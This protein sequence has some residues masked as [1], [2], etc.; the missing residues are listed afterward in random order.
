MPKNASNSTI[1]R[2]KETLGQ[3]DVNLLFRPSLSSSGFSSAQRAQVNFL[4]MRTVKNK[5]SELKNNRRH[6]QNHERNAKMQ[7]DICDKQSADTAGSCQ[8][9][10]LVARQ[11]WP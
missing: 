10:I 11:D 4:Q 3:I 5:A 9:S 6:S 2:I 8:L 7:L 1:F